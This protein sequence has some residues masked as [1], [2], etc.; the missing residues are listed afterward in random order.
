[1][2]RNRLLCLKFFLPLGFF[3]GIIYFTKHIEGRISENF[4]DI[5]KRF[6][7]IET[8]CINCYQNRR[9]RC[10]GTSRKLTKLSGKRGCRYEVGVGT[11]T[12][13]AIGCHHLCREKIITTSCCEG[14][15]GRDCQSCPK[16]PAGSVCGNRAR[17]FDGYS[18]NGTCNCGEN[19]S[20]SYCEICSKPQYYGPLCRSVCACVHGTCNSGIN[21]TGACYCDD[22]YGGDRC[23]QELEACSQKNCHENAKCQGDG[24]GGEVFCVCNRGYTGDGDSC[25]Q[26]NPCVAGTNTPCSVNATCVHTGPDQSTC[27]CKDGFSGD[28]YW[29]AAIDPCQTNN[30]GCNLTSSTCVFGAPGQSHCECK[31]GFEEQSNQCNLVNICGHY[32][33]T[34]CADEATCETILL[35]EVITVKCTCPEGLLE[36]DRGCYDDLLSELYKL[37][38]T[39]SFANQLNNALM[40]FDN[41]LEKDLL[42]PYSW[43][44]FV[45]LD[46]AFVGE[47]QA[48]PFEDNKWKVIGRAHTVAGSMLAD[49]QNSSAKTMYPL[50]GHDYPITLLRPGALPD[51]NPDD[52]DD[53]YFADLR[54]KQNMLAKVRVDAKPALNGMI[55]IIDKI[56][57]DPSM[58]DFTQN[59]TGINALR[60][61]DSLSQFTGLAS[62]NPWLTIRL[63]T[64]PTF[65]L[66]APN[67]DA[68]AEFSEDDMSFLQSAQ[69]AVI[70]KDI[71]MYNLASGRNTMLAF[72]L[73]TSPTVYT[74]QP[75]TLNRSR[76]DGAIMLGEEQAKILKT[77]I[78][79]NSSDSSLV[80]YIHIVDKFLI[81]PNMKP[82]VKNRCEETVDNTVR[83]PCGDCSRTFCKPGGLPLSQEIRVSKPCVY[84]IQTE[85]DSGLVG[86]ETR[87]GCSIL[88]SHRR[89]VSKCCAGF[90]GKECRSCKGPPHNACNGNGVCSDSTRG[91]GLCRCNTGFSGDSCNT[92]SNI[93]KFGPRCDQD[94]ACRNGVCKNA[95]DSRGECKPQTCQDGWSGE[96]CD[97]EVVLCENGTLACHQFATCV[98]EESGNTSC[99]CDA[100]Y[101]GSGSHCEL[102]DPCNIQNNEYPC[103]MSAYCYNL[104]R[105]NYSCQC[106]P[107]FEGNGK[108]C[109]PIDNC[110]SDNRG[111]CSENANCIYTG[112]GRHSCQCNEGYRGNGYICSE[113]NVCQEDNG[114]CGIRA[115]CKQTGPGRRQ[116]DCFDGYES[117]GD[118]CVGNI[119]QEIASR[120]DLSQIHSWVS[121]WRSIK[122]LLMN[123]NAKFTCFFPTDSAWRELSD[124]ERNLWLTEQ[125]LPYIIKRHIAPKY[126]QA[127]TLVKLK[128]QSVQTLL[129]TVEISINEVTADS[130]DV[131][132]DTASGTSETRN[133][134]TIGKLFYAKLIKSDIPVSKSGV[135]HIIDSVLV[136]PKDVITDY[137]SLSTILNN[138]PG[139]GF[140]KYGQFISYLNSSGALALLEST[141]SPY[142]LFL[143][144][145]SAFATTNITT[146]STNVTVYYHIILGKLIRYFNIRSGEHISPYAGPGFLLTVVSH[147]QSLLVNGLS[148]METAN[149]TDKGIV[150]RLTDKILI[151]QRTRCDKAMT[152]HVQT[153]CL[154]CHFP[155]RCPPS[156]KPVIETHCL[157]LHVTSGGALKTGTGCRWRCNKNITQPKCCPGFYGDGCD[158]CPGGPGNICFKSGTCFDGMKGNGTCTCSNPKFSGTACETCTAGRYGRTCDNLCKCQNGTCNDGIDGD[159]TCVCGKGVR[160]KYCDRL[161]DPNDQCNQ[162]CHSAAECV[163]NKVGSEFGCECTTGYKG[164]G[165]DCQAVNPCKDPSIAHGCHEQAICM[166]ISAGIH[167]CTCKENYEGDGRYCSPINPCLKPYGQKC[168]DNANCYMI[169]PNVSRCVCR[170]F[171][172]GDGKSCRQADMCQK[173]Y[174]GCSENAICT[175][176]DM[177][178]ERTC[179]CKNDYFGNGFNCTGSIFSHINGKPRF[180][181]FTLMDMFASLMPHV[182][183]GA[184]PIVALLPSQSIMMSLNSTW[185][186]YEAPATQLYLSHIVGCFDRSNLSGVAKM[187]TLAGDVLNVTETDS[188]F[189]INNA[190]RTLG[191][192]LKFWNGI[193]YEID[194]PLIPSSLTRVLSKAEPTKLTKILQPYME[195]GIDKTTPLY[196]NTKKLLAIGFPWVVTL[197]ETA[198]ELETL[199]YP[200]HN[201]WMLLL[202][203]EKAFRLQTAQRLRS[204]M[205][206]DDPTYASE[207]IRYH[208]IRET[209]V[210]PAD[211]MNFGAKDTNL[212]TMQGSTIT[213][214]CA[215][216]SNVYGQ[217]TVNNGMANVVGIGALHFTTQTQEEK[218]ASI[219]VIDKVL[220]PPSIGGRCDNEKN[221]EEQSPCTLCI[222]SDLKCQG[223]TTLVSRDECSLPIPGSGSGSIVNVPGCSITCS[224]YKKVHSCCPHYYGASC[225]ACP[226]GANSP[227]SGNGKCNDGI[228][229]TGKCLCK[230]GFVGTA[231]EACDTGR[232]GRNCLMCQCS[233][234]GHCNGG[235]NGDGS[236]FCDSGWAGDKCDQRTGSTATC[237]P[238]CHEDG[239][240]LDSGICYCKPGYGGDGVNQCLFL[241]MCYVNN[242]GCS[243]YANCEIVHEQVRC[244]C[245]PKFVGDGTFCEPYDPCTT[246]T[247]TCHSMATCVVNS[248]TNSSNCVCK[249]GYQGDGVKTCDRRKA[250]TCNINNGGC[251]GKAQ[252]T[253]VP[254]TI[255]GALPTT[256]CKCNEGSL[257][258]GITCHG[259]V[260]SII[261]ESAEMRNFYDQL[262]RMPAWFKRKLGAFDTNF[263]VFVPTQ[264]T[265]AK[266]PTYAIK[267]HVIKGQ[268]LYFNQLLKMSSVSVNPRVSLPVQVFN[269]NEVYINSRKIQKSDIIGTNGIIHMIDKFIP[270]TRKTITIPVGTTTASTTSR[271]STSKKTTKKTQVSVKSKTT[272]QTTKSATVKPGVPM[273]QGLTPAIKVASFAPA[274]NYTAVTK[275]KGVTF[276]GATKAP[277]SG[278]G[279]AKVAVPIVIILIVLAIA[280]GVAF[281]WWRNRHT[282]GF[283]LFRERSGYEEPVEDAFAGLTNPAYDSTGFNTTDNDDVILKD[284]DEETALAMKGDD[285]PI[286]FENP[287]RT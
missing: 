238:A 31:D 115:K 92:C 166:M 223:N 167:N 283:S 207:Y 187:R 59:T 170:E 114:G 274:S 280:G 263:T 26:I 81:P 56:L 30:G 55:Y 169:A 203:T 80:G 226:G 275:S 234:Y 3:F 60:N 10:P 136:P 149:R 242:G 23:E 125:H 148:V 195:N 71:L 200:L 91:T 262:R 107:A 161:V 101:T 198:G 1:M 210:S 186:N 216:S 76:I 63:N 79:L 147:H 57:Y 18:G 229:G 188:G 260:M 121:R 141:E 119:L 209:F 129:K 28:G 285:G 8:T 72:K 232:Y 168:D 248:Q 20:G 196:K 64:P 61:I 138:S 113:I 58:D 206:L 218:K 37:N 155:S 184:S 134:P 270:T 2:D 48:L 139:S 62:I 43:T 47:F 194:Q 171:F 205:N 106:F 50:L 39:G 41:I 19:L 133:L 277:T 230:R 214:K 73:A 130:R 151:P 67:N 228:D 271:R 45:A 182:L 213:I 239:Y 240:C 247:M 35:G 131:N 245:R 246:L 272:Q 122:S 227:C 22:G 180:S 25:A 143:A 172:E 65:A 211:V 74:S 257:G 38:A 85:R 284:T 52:D 100:G 27:R 4:C 128:G 158:P 14:Y 46:S 16:D 157:F 276:D 193:L 87:L 224:S 82:L 201:P 190:V 219:Y 261:R 154:P 102:Y 199:Q 175:T 84:T 244:K 235:I 243:K 273:D 90:Y 75:V 135:I 250:K 126:M 208:M 89:N 120:S 286:S 86:F 237:D 225:H 269:G 132:I 117:I 189:L 53:G 221:A 42:N 99:V 110:Q 33:S 77:D 220:D 233:V 267:R 197:L 78:I 178:G 104:G 68:M 7:I 105:G 15:W 123:L 252:C 54:Y 217:M 11:G 179:K 5:S 159:G 97:R 264:V 6:N 93:S 98:V 282:G 165:K 88:C 268:F 258:D 142:T 253:D 95:I 66:F 173:D 140:E 236:C 281:Y 83:G 202:P 266:R 118:A 12:R 137:P 103:S 13:R 265:R 241:D 162:T 34:T 69:G 144:P 40:L 112:P 116:C 176:G 146:F 164:D 251:S 21:G 185:L 9:V 156:S 49:F 254:P 259:T 212:R 255:T 231:C 278:P 287:E 109:T 153:Q 163:P 222:S 191:T 124:D 192:P 177:P 51:D 204:F 183:S 32:E 29:C 256:K 24:R 108:T 215:A 181:W 96:N 174:G 150:Y 152:T 70:L 249:P 17:C 44:L 127:I 160:G 94:C 111:G 36:F 279:G 145:D